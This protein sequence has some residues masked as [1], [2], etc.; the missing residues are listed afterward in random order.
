MKYFSPETDEMLACPCCGLF[1]MRPEAEA[2]FDLA[3]SISGISYRVL[4]GCRCE[5]YNAQLVKTKKAS[6]D[7]AHIARPG[8]G[9]SAMD[10][11][12]MTDAERYYILFGLLSAGFK[13]ILIYPD[14]NFIHADL[15]PDKPKP[16][17]KIMKKKEEKK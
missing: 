1:N 6:E 5:K 7:S 10:I 2:A 8:R 9:S 4:S 3:R 12:A 16:L 17:V 13:R 14:N 11:A 15:D